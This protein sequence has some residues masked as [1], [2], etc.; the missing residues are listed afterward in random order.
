MTPIVLRASE[1]ARFEEVDGLREL[2]LRD[3][4]DG[5]IA[6]GARV[7]YPAMIDFCG[8]SLCL[9]KPGLRW[10]S[11]A[12][13]LASELEKLAKSPA[14]E[15]T[16][17]VL[18]D[19]GFA[20]WRSLAE[21]AGLF[22][23]DHLAWGEVKESMPAATALQ[24]RVLFPLELGL[25]DRCYER[26]LNW[27]APMSRGPCVAVWM[28]M[29]GPKSTWESLETQAFEL[30]FDELLHLIHTGDGYPPGTCWS[31]DGR[32][33]IANDRI[34]HCAAIGTRMQPLG[35]SLSTLGLEWVPLR[36]D[37]PLP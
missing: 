30:E 8:C 11:D 2:T 33:W 17:S 37:H 13:A 1:R 36:P 24:R 18:P 34:R 35:A 31:L 19:G 5:E 21:V 10:H 3:R 25:H 26:I 22:W 28:P 29:D 32:W 9:S 14:G 12:L 6:W 15:P 16:C 7:L 23:S 27:L 4:L 20:T